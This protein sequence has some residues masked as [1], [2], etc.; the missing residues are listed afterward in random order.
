MIFRKD[1]KES[2][3]KKICLSGNKQQSVRPPPPSYYE[4]LKYSHISKSNEK[5]SKFICNGKLHRDS[6]TID[7]VDLAA[8][9]CGTEGFP[10]A[11]LISIEKHNFKTRDHTLESIPENLFEN[12]DMG[13]KTLTDDRQTEP[14][15][16]NI[17]ERGSLKSLNKQEI[18]IDKVDSGMCQGGSKEKLVLPNGVILH[19]SIDV[20]EP[21]CPSPSALKEIE[22][23]L[24]LDEFDDN[25]ISDNDEDD[26]CDEDLNGDD[27]GL[28][29]KEDALELVR[30]TE[31]SSLPDATGN[32]FSPCDSLELREND[33]QCIHISSA[34]KVLSDVSKTLAQ[35][36]N[37][38][39][40]KTLKRTYND[41][42]YTVYELSPSD[43]FNS[44]AGE[45]N[46]PCVQ[47]PSSVPSQEQMVKLCG[48]SNS[49]TDSLKM[50][51]LKRTD[52]LKERLIRIDSQRERLIRTGSHKERLTR[53]YSKPE[54]SQPPIQQLRK[55]SLQDEIRRESLDE[56]KTLI[57]T[58][59]DNPE[60]MSE[61]SPMEN[62]AALDLT[63]EGTE[64]DFKG[65][66]ADRGTLYCA[67]V[68]VIL[69][70]TLVFLLI[71][72]T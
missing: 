41:M 51:R 69:V 21:P 49:L 9:E 50:E 30:V 55:F 65:R 35:V 25:H 23:D 38:G 40:Q 1:T 56:V 5:N 6:S 13:L 4:A 8:T 59:T 47:P 42:N 19:T 71:F 62:L 3:T 14:L 45:T 52:S 63:F 34:D 12:N 68:G 60:V 29:D 39:N 27:I 31:A 67:C 15:L 10:G 33:I 7:G 48:N 46:T 24:A 53:M 43:S 26:T 54:E 64:A 57:A 18:G 28:I 66:A 61:P 2:F 16:K 22:I 36:S 58:K 32:K 70:V 20:I 44:S 72:F 11:I 37:C 17:D